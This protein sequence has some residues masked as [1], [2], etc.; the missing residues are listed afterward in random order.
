MNVS[1]MICYD[2]CISKSLSSMEQ[3]DGEAVEGPIAAASTL[4]SSSSSSSETTTVGLTGTSSAVD[5][6]LGL[7][8]VPPL[9]SIVFFCALHCLRN[10]APMG[11][12][13]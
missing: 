3:R 10:V 5:F 7:F 1:I 9:G 4:A 13:R 12:V 8:V 11:I 6:T 2:D